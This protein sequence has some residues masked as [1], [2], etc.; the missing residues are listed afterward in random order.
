MQ[1]TLEYDSTYRYRCG[2]CRRSFVVTSREVHESGNAR[3]PACLSDDVKQWIS[4][5][6]RLM[7]FLMLYEA[8]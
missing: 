1:L 3:C 6:D 7:R 5:R 4:R 8:A 2:S